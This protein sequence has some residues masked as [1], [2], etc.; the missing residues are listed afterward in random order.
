MSR[1]FLGPSDW[2]KLNGTS[3]NIVYTIHAGSICEYVPY[4][5][6]F[7]GFFEESNRDELKVKITTY[8]HWINFLIKKNII[9]QQI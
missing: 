6:V 2:R 7:L 5:F 9:I 3:V 4:L 8:V 1:D